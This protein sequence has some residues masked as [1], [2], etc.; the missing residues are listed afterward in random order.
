MAKK[1]EN[2]IEK[3]FNNNG[4]A[5]EE[6]AYKYLKPIFNFIFR[7]TKNIQVAE[8][9]TQETFIKAWK[10]LKRYDRKRSFKTWLFTIAKNTAYDYFK[11]K[12]TI[13]F[14]YFEDMEGN[15]FLENIEE[16]IAKPEESLDLE[17]NLKQLE[18]ALEKIPAHYQEVLILCYKEDFTL[19]EIAEI[20][21][22]PYNTVK[23]RHSRAITNLKKHIAPK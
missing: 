10:N 9:L 11:K 14:A 2:S 17:I 18:M 22:E 16:D 15:S 19:Q 5:F 7:L 4:L 21:S 6:L 3:K 20:L 1:R 13:P 12:K 8:D 23:N